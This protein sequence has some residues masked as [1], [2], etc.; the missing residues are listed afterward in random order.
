M[1]SLSAEVWPS[2]VAMPETAMAVLSAVPMREVTIEPDGRAVV[3]KGRPI[4][5]RP[6]AAWGTTV[7]LSSLWETEVVPVDVSLRVVL[8]GVTYS[9]PG[10][11]MGQVGA[12]VDRAE[13]LR[14]CEVSIGAARK[15][16]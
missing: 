10:D 2:V 4:M 13:W 11:L 3:V 16:G 7:V 8:A 6:D 12:G 9:T 14:R 1:A 5:S 15:A